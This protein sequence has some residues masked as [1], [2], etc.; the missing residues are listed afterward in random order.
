LSQGINCHSVKIFYAK[1]VE[2]RQGV[3]EDLSQKRGGKE[4]GAEARDRGIK[5]FEVEPK[6]SSCGVSNLQWKDKERGSGFTN[7][8]VNYQKT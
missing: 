2:K 5:D 3:T 1:Q 4:R 8:C 7:E 6:P